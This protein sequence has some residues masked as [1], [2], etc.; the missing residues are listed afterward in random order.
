MVHCGGAKVKI[1]GVKVGH[2]LD[3]Y[4]YSMNYGRWEGEGGENLMLKAQ[5]KRHHIT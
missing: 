3:E 2:G 4:L 5:L 1:I